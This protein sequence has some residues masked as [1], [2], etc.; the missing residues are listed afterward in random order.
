LGEF[1]DPQIVEFIEAFKEKYNREE[2]T[3]RFTTAE[4]I[5]DANKLIDT[6][7]VA[8]QAQAA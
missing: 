6:I 3:Q 2:F 8:S 7:W 5:A 4:D 1:R